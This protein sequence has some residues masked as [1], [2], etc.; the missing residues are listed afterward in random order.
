GGGPEG[1]RRGG[2]VERG[3][4]AADAFRVQLL[5]PVRVWR[6]DAELRLGPPR[7]RALFA[8]LAFRRDRVVPRWELINAMWGEDAPATAE[9]SVYTYLSGLRKVLEPGRS[10]RAPSAVRPPGGVGYGLRLAAGTVD[11]ETF[12]ARSADAANAL[13]RGAADDAFALADQAL[14]MWQGEPLSGLPGP[15][16][17]ARRTQ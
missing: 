12:E 14:A 13:A 8:V 1:Q 4:L 17:E 15:F 3:A 5:G 10:G 6:G 7:Q 9:G 2:P 11:V 16:A